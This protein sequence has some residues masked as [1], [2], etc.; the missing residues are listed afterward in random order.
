M[1]QA[2]G[3]QTCSFPH[4][5]L[6]RLHSGQAQGRTLQ[7]LSL[8]LGSRGKPWANRGQSSNEPDLSPSRR[9]RSS[10]PCHS[11]GGKSCQTGRGVVVSMLDQTEPKFQRPFSAQTQEFRRQIA[12]RIPR[13]LPGPSGA[14]GC[15]RL[16]ADHRRRLRKRLPMHGAGSHVRRS[17]NRVLCA[18][19]PPVPARVWSDVFR[20]ERRERGPD[21]ASAAVPPLPAVPGVGFARVQISG[22]RRSLLLHRDESAPALVQRSFRRRGSQ[23]S[24]LVLSRPGRKRSAVADKREATERSLLDQFQIG[25]GLV[26]PDTEYGSHRAARLVAL[27][28]A[29]ALLCMVQLAGSSTVPAGHGRSSRRRHLACVRNTSQKQSWAGCRCAR[30]EEEPKVGFAEILGGAFETALTMPAMERRRMRAD[31]SACE[32]RKLQSLPLQRDTGEPRVIGTVTQQSADLATVET[33]ARRG[34]VRNVY[35]QA[36]QIRRGGCTLYVYD[37]GPFAHACRPGKAAQRATITEQ[38]PGCR[39]EDQ[40]VAFIARQ[41]A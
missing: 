14:D 24:L 15:N 25:S 12:R 33:Q 23:H 32:A 18:Q 22:R 38:A 35:S 11:A 17:G 3:G 20:P 21:S 37:H 40:T 30:A 6:P 1:G 34:T 31:S 28:G 41:S 19:A 4:V 39:H 2:P 16:P 10:H 26:C 36:R 7:T 9:A 5:R 29:G 13:L 27:S 8:S